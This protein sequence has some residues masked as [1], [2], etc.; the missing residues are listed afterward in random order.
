MRRA[1]RRPRRNP[2]PLD[3][4]AFRRWFGESVVVDERGEPLVV[5]HGTDKVFDVFRAHSRSINTTTFGPVETERTGIFL[6]TNP[7]FSAEYGRRLMR[8]YASIEDPAEITRDLVLA[9]ADSLDPFGAERELWLQAKYSRSAWTLFD[10]ELGRRFVAFLRSHEH[11]GATFDENVVVEDGEIAG[12]TYVAFDPTQIKSATDNV[13][14]YDPS[15]PSIL[16]NRRSSR[17]AR[18]TSRRSR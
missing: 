8:V 9:F 1:S 4:P 6:S 17:R 15:D 18:R 13:G 7:A 14:T 2:S 3:N 5:Y 10:G 16:K 12:R 11:D